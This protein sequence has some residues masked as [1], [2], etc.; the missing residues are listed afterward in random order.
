MSLSLDISPLHRLVV[1]AASGHVTPEEIGRISQKLIAANVPHYGKIVD[2]TLATSNLTKEQVDH[3]AA[4][5]RG[6][7]GAGRGP[8]AFVSSPDRGV[9]TRA[10]ADATQGDR[11]VKVFHTLREARQWLA[12]QPRIEPDGSPLTMARPPTS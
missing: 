3:I 1:I 10:F 4:M 5:L 12:E 8:V 6:D 7:R 9:F 11:P 2:A